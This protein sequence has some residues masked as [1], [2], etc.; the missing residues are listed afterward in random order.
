MNL[1]PPSS[2]KR[3]FGL[4]FLRAVAIL[5]V[6][7]DHSTSYI[8]HKYQFWFYLPI[9]F[10]DGVT[11]FFVLSGYLIGN[12]FLTQFYGNDFS[13]KKIVRF[14]IRR[15]LRTLPAFYFV[16]GVFFLYI[17]ISDK[18]L[19]QF[20]FKIF[21]FVQNFLSPPPNWFLEA[22]S[23]SVEEWFYV[24]FPVTIF[25]VSFIFKRKKNILLMVISIFLLLPLTLRLY[26]FYT[27]NFQKFPLIEYRNVVLFRL[28]SVM[29]GVLAAAVQK[30]FYSFLKSRKNILL[31]IGCIIFVFRFV[32]VT[33]AI[34]MNLYFSVLLFTIE[35]FAIFLCIPFFA[36]WQID[37][38]KYFFS[39]TI[40]II[41]VVSYSA[42]LLNKTT[43]QNVI[44]IEFLQRT[45]LD[46]V[47]W[48]YLT[49]PVYFAYWIIVMILSVSLHLLIEKPVMQWRD[50][51]FI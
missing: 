30:R 9:N 13:F 20:S 29:F 27:D 19:E 11:V 5:W 12:I 37:F 49:I 28:D 35:P 41:S 39:K 18:A 24:L 16:Y 42:Y 3:I 31:L 14:W 47:S 10:F 32:I 50:R 33:F 36:D 4:D 6:V 44:I 25:V 21:F 46:K 38:R 17:L 7:Y 22:W 45:H 40:T 1:L 51:K 48:V 2:S 15:W 34:R 43:I 23:L 26:Y 8:N